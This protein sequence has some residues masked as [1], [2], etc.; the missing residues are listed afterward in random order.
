MHSDCYDDILLQR[1]FERIGQLDYGLPVAIWWAQDKRLQVLLIRIGGTALLRATKSYY[2]RSIT[3]DGETWAQRGIH[4]QMAAEVSQAERHVARLV[5]GRDARDLPRDRVRPVI[6]QEPQQ[7]QKRA[8]PEHG[9]EK[10][11]ES[12]VG[13]FEQRLQRR[14]AASRGEAQFLAQQ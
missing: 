6:V 3:R 10:E 2:L 5:L 14:L 4:I 1:S 7:G 9:Q 13:L 8:F 11:G 12:E